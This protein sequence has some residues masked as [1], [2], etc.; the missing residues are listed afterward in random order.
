MTARLAI[1][2]PL[3]RDATTHDKL[4]RDLVTWV[5]GIELAVVA[6]FLV[7][8]IVLSTFADLWV[9]VVL[10]LLRSAEL[11][12]HLARGTAPIRSFLQTDTRDP[13]SL[14]RVERALAT[15]PRQYGIHCAIGWLVMVGLAMALGW[16]GIPR[17]VAL[18]HTELVFGASIGLG[19]ALMVPVHLRPMLDHVLLD[20][21]R[22]LSHALR[23]R[24]LEPLTTHE[25]LGRSTLIFKT[26]LATGI[27]LILGGILV[28]EHALHLRDE[29]LAEQVTRAQL[30]AT[31]LRHGELDASALGP[32]L[33]VVQRSAE[34]PAQL[35]G[36]SPDDEGIV[37][38]H[39]P[40]TERSMA[41]AVLDDQRWVVAEAEV[42]QHVGL[43]LLLTLALLPALAGPTLLAS[44]AL[45]RSL[46]T[47]IGQLEDATRKLADEGDFHGFA[48]L[49]PLRRD[50]LGR[51]A[52]NLNR[53]VDVFD[54]LA[55]AASA[56]AEGDLS[57][58]LGGQGDLPNA[59]RSMLEQLHELASQIRLT[60][61]ELT[62][63]AAEIRTSTGEQ[64]HAVAQ[65]SNRVLLVTETM[66][67]LAAGSGEINESASEVL[68]NAERTLITTG[69][70]AETLDSL[71]TAAG[72][73]GEL[74]EM[75]REIADRSDILALNGALE[76][77]RAGEAGQGFALIA[78][79]MRRLAERVTATVS[80]VRERIAD[81]EQATAGT[82]NATKSSRSIADSTAAAARQI[83][84]ISERQSARTYEA[85]A[86]VVEVDAGM[87]TTVNAVR[88]TLAAAE[89]LRDL[90]IELERLTGRF[91]LRE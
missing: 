40:R 4:V 58:E 46:S 15:L 31:Q 25:S 24:E 38:N 76:A 77:G 62:T 32:G 51:V 56:V 42:D 68:A 73:I 8:N 84:A 78:E 23:A 45:S 89:G 19:I 12:A 85:S 21:Q 36:L 50:G 33:R 75:I 70:V 48:R 67:S 74:L 35:A 49:V 26:A 54:E 1:L 44:W 47:S 86:Q 9:L 80:Q 82:I 16:L 14:R 10:S 83:S 65:Q 22:E 6:T 37:S 11:L 81:I 72:R 71:A 79:E 64:E 5:V 55:S 61:L 7:F 53:M 69:Q 57:I 2:R 18:G 27:T 30:A 28:H 87:T 39:A 20:T 17:P 43:L 29:S 88:Q 90:A 34:L 52:I 13:E 60:S 59:F 66:L 91:K 3:A 41:A 63:A